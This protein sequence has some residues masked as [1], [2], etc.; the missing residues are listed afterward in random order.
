MMDGLNEPTLFVEHIGEDAYVNMCA[1]FISPHM[2][3]T[4]DT[5]S[6]PAIPAA[7]V[8]HAQCQQTH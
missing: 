1:Y 3:A 8:V 5:T 2:A 6:V 4:R 7:E